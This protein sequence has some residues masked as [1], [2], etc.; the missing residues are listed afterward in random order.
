M[1][2]T[3]NKTIGKIINNSMKISKKI[4][5]LA[6]NNNQENEINNNDLEDE[7]NTEDTDDFNSILNYVKKFN[8]NALEKSQ[9]IINSNFSEFNNKILE[10][11]IKNDNEF[12]NNKININQ[13]D[14]SEKI[15][16][17]ITP[18]K[19]LPK[20]FNNL[21]IYLNFGDFINE[22]N[23][24]NLNLYNKYSDITNCYYET[25]TYLFDE[26]CNKIS[27]LAKTFFIS[28]EIK[29]NYQN[30][31]NEYTEKI[32]ESFLKKIFIN[33]KEINNLLNSI[34][35]YY[36]LHIKLYNKNLNQFT[37]LQTKKLLIENPDL[38]VCEI[39]ENAIKNNQD[40][41]FYESFLN[42]SDYVKNSSFKILA[43]QKIPSLTKFLNN[44]NPIFCR[45]LS[46]SN[47]KFKEN[48]SFEDLNNI[49]SKKDKI[50]KLLEKFE[51]E[52]LN[53]HKNDL[54]IAKNYM[55]KGLE[56]NIEDLL[57]RE[58]WK[59]HTKNEG[60]KIINNYFEDAKV[61]LSE[62]LQRLFEKFKSLRAEFNKSIFD[63]NCYPTQFINKIAQHLSEFFIENMLELN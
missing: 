55:I 11:F 53:T 61:K 20:E 19:T 40:C 41:K 39:F 28:E 56:F 57:K 31:F 33:N 13:L 51:S 30:F 8:N 18:G 48:G 9:D 49:L 43:K 58:E 35:E 5:N 23:W 44:V 26:F 25:Y 17:F 50:L 10:P 54:E 14:L 42:I 3:G 59:L 1:F 36:N 21:L 15:I 2:I 27:L 45:I 37:F 47:I 7:I 22:E 24:N 32:E 4:F 38:I 63:Y 16:N 34:L 6:F 29:K 52:I 60:L 12:L 62:V 46:D